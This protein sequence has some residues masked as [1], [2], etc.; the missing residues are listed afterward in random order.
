[1]GLGLGLAAALVTL[2]VTFAP[3]FLW[4]FAGAPYVEWIATRPRLQGALDAITAAVVG[5]IANLSLWFALHVVFGEVTRV[6]TPGGPGLWLPTAASVD[7][8]AV[9]LTALAAGAGVLAAARPADR[10]AADG[11][12]RAGVEPCVRRDLI[13]CRRHPRF[14]G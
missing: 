14:R 2:W 6:G 1:V 4:I 13:P 5:V 7:I 12:G 9:I 8:G 10:P 3:C 11:T